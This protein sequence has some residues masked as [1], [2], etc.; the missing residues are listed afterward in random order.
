MGDLVENVANFASEPTNG[1]VRQFLMLDIF[2]LK[3]PFEQANG[4]FSTE[5]GW[6]HYHHN[7]Y[8]S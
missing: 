2:N 6:V 1:F 5:P 4:T 3:K 8:S 7:L